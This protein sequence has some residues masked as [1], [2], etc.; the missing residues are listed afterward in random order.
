MN[1]NKPIRITM[2]SINISRINILLLFIVFGCIFNTQI[3]AAEIAVRLKDLSRIEGNREL[4]LNGYGIV[5]GL[6]GSGDSSR[7]RATLQSLANTLSNFGLQVDE[8]DLN[9]RNVA[10]VIITAELPAYSE[11]GDR[12]DIRVASTGDAK[13]LSGGTLLLAPMYG[14]DKKLYALS[15]GA[16][17]VG[18]YDV[19]SFSNRSRKN[20]TTV[21]QIARG[22]TIE[23]PSPHVALKSHHINIILNEPDYTTANRV[24]NEIRR[25]LGVSEVSALHP[26]KISLTLAEDIQVMPFIARLENITVTPDLDARVVVNERTGTIV[27]GSNVI[28]G[29][30][31]IAHG[32][33]RIEVVT[34]F[35]TTQPQ[36]NFRSGDGIRTVVT[37]DTNI[38]V[39]EGHSE[40]VSLP[41]GTTVGEL[42]QALNRIRLSTR[43]VITILQSI[44]AAGAL[45]AELIIQ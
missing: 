15:Q 26:G 34:K 9:S 1:K 12:I 44:K 30:I 23:R 7:H 20:H 28:L 25:T 22:A 13:S 21:G 36:L 8:R 10:S 45:H 42:V 18:G 41:A 17:T 27:A 37:P 19:S 11:P 2:P 33:L 40:P 5:V 4:A 31:S 32:D 38:V 6:S 16:L 14:P 24:V 43:D 29:Q 39:T 35:D 3:H